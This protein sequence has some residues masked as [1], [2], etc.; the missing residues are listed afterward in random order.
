MEMGKNEKGI[1]HLCDL[2]HG[3]GAGTR[4]GIVVLQERV[5]VVYHTRV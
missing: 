5:E 1:R 4:G 2:G 3:D